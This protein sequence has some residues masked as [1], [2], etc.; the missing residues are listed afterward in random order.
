MLL[1]GQARRPG[2][3]GFP[4]GLPLQMRTLSR[5]AADPSPARSRAEDRRDRRPGHR[6]Q[7]SG[8]LVPY[9]MI[10]H[11]MISYD[12]IQYHMSNYDIVH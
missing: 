2:T 1:V 11:H 10:C 3:A 9:D 12:D 8:L 6:I 7:A 4:P 5:A